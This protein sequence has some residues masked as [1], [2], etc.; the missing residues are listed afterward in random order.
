MLITKHEKLI[1]NSFS[2][3]YEYKFIYL[4]SKNEKEKARNLKHF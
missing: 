2:V 3:L 1:K 4:Y